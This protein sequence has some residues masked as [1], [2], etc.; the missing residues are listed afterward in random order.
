M[1]YLVINSVYVINVCCEW[2][3]RHIKQWNQQSTSEIQIK[4][5]KA[6]I[7][8]WMRTFVKFE[9]EKTQ[10]EQKEWR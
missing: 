5:R 3:Q 8:K 4:N 10:S 9:R 6:Q 1:S 2:Q 7:I